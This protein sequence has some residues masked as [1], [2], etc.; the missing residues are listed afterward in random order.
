MTSNILGKGN[1]V[2]FVSQESTHQVMCSQSHHFFLSQLLLL[3]VLPEQETK[4]MRLPLS[5]DKPGL[6]SQ[7][8]RVGMCGPLTKRPTLY[9]IWDQIRDFPNFV[10]D[11]TT[12][13]RPDP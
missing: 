6:H 13:S 12:N 9:M 10:Y 5:Y 8:N 1:S 7:K 2:D 3:L 4:A 11:M